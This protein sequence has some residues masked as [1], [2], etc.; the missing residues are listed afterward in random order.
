MEVWEVFAQKGHAD[1]FV[2]VGAVAAPDEEMATAYAKEC[3]FRRKD[4][5]AMWLVRRSD[6][7]APN[8]A[9]L[10]EQI[11]DKSY[12]YPEAYRGVVEKRVAARIR[13]AALTGGRSAQRVEEKTAGDEYV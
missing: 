10:F 7:H 4:G 13:G 1:P 6:V 3:F 8:D 9:Q 2:H 5:I 11:T 12:R